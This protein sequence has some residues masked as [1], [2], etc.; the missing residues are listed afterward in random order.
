MFTNM[1]VA[2]KLA[3]GYGVVLL[4]MVGILL[5]GITNMMRMNEASERILHE[6]YPKTVI[7]NDAIARTLDNGRSTRNLLLVDTP[8]VVARN[9]TLIQENRARIRQLLADLDPQ[10]HAPKGRELM[11]AILRHRDALEPKYE[12]LMTLAQADRARAIEFQMNS[13]ATTNTAFAKALRD[14]AD[15][16]GGKMEE[17]GDAIEAAN[18]SARNQML[19]VGLVAMLAALAL[20]GATIRGLSRQLGGEPAEAV[21]VANAIAEG[22]LNA[23][24][25]VRSGDTTSVIAAMRR[26]NDNLAQIVGQVRNS[27]DSIATGSEQIATGNADLS[28]RTEEQASNLQQ[29]AA[30]MEQLSSTVKVNAE[31]TL[32][33]NQLAAQASAAA[34][35]GG[36]AVGTVVATMQDIATSSR[37]IADIIGVID[38]IAFQTNILALNAAVEAAR[39]GEQGRGFAV[40]A[41]EVRNLAGRAAEAAREIKSLIGASVDKVEVGAR[42]VHDAGASMTEIV[43]QVARVT[44]LIGEISHATTEQASG[45]GQVGDA[46]MQLDQVTQQNAALVEESAAAAESLKHQAARLAQA[47]SV[48]KIGQLAQ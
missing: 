8:D 33:A 28:Q 46:V 17:E 25:Q 1:R 9:V 36:E 6:R 48:F 45:I 41:G 38:A 37:R 19:G 39:A 32:Q 4:L 22:D 26:M 3:L 23:R 43:A 35:K 24:F 7:V 18:L 12:E 10:V 29:T 44:Q 20:A 27:S 21:Q 14:M 11:T 16:Q 30:S 5:L 34:A 40:V 47:V 42:Q 31:T 2:V 15:Y 13:F